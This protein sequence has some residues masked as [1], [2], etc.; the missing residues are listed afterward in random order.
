MKLKAAN[1]ER[2]KVLTRKEMFEKTPDDFPSHEISSATDAIKL[3]SDAENKIDR[4]NKKIIALTATI[5]NCE[6][7]T[8]INNVEW[9]KIAIEDLVQK[10]CYLAHAERVKDFR[11]YAIDNNLRRP[12]DGLVSDHKSCCKRF[13]LKLC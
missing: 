10:Y 4:I 1:T 11:R 9:R 3:M 13:L 2:L 6:K 5:K 12:W 8:Q 7:M